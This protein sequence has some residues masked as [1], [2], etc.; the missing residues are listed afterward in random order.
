M[1][2]SLGTSAFLWGILSSVSLL[3]GAA[4]GLWLKPGRKVNAVFMSFGA[5]ALLFAL[6]IELFG[7]VP[8]HAEE[9]GINSL[10]AALVGAVIGGLL[11]NFLNTLL[12][13]RGAFLRN[14]STARQYIGFLK[15]SRK[16][17]LI[18]E[19]SKIDLLRYVPP[20]KMAFLVHRIKKG[21]YNVGETVFSQGDDPKEMY[22]VCDGEVDIILHKEN[23]PDGELLAS[24]K[25]GDTF[26]ELGVLGGFPRTADAVAKTDLQVYRIGKEDIQEVMTHCIELKS[27]LE[28][29]SA[30]RIDSLERKSPDMN[31]SWKDQTLRHLEDATSS[32]S[33]E[34][35][36]EEATKGAAG[37]AGMAIWLGILL[38]GIPESLVI[39]MLAASASGMSLAFVAGVFLA[40][41]PEAMSSALSMRSQGM[42][43]LTIYAMW[44]SIVLITGIGA[45]LGATMFPPEPTGNIF[46]FIIGIEGLAAGAM[47]TMIAQTMLPEAFEQG[48]SI[49]GLSTLGGF[50]SALVVKI[51]AA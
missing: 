36:N 37:G 49:I 28:D 4:L 40:N 23:D 10:F 47:L 43:L 46:F 14:L 44:G 30:E 17:K 31:I 45:F 29:L 38:D 2:L 5:G 42:K 33:V 20:D 3:I 15:F 27:A 22:F 11:F 21:Q 13:N 34:E 32:V 26:G 6:T 50:L 41:F 8:H 48:G 19:L 1:G 16:S 12:N 39:G 18:E 24:L 9:H 25:T 7:H 35:I 51:V